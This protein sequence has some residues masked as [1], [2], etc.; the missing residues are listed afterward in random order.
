MKREEFLKQVKRLRNEGKTIRVIAAELSVHRSSVHR[1][2][3][4]LEAK[5]EAQGSESRI[6]PSSGG[7][8]GRQH[9]IEKL[10]AALEYTLSWTGCIVMLFGDPGIGKT[11]TAHELSAVAR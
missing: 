8:V 1:A 9:E 2:L 10:A 3:K 11:R 7:F 6:R 5:I 4:T